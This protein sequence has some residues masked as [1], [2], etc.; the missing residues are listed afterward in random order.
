MPDLQNFAER[1]RRNG[2][3]RPKTVRFD[4]FKRF[5]MDRFLDLQIEA[6]A[7]ALRL[8]ADP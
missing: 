1:Y 4:H 5:V 3:I 2:V 7:L 8:R 6:P